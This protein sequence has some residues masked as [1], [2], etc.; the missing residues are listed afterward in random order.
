LDRADVTYAEPKALDFNR[1]PDDLGHAPLED[2]RRPLQD[3]VI[4]SE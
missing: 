3:G 4:L 1:Q 2:Q